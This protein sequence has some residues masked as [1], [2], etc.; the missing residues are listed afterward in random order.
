MT[1][2]RNRLLY[3]ISIVIVIILGLF[4]RKM[5]DKMPYFLKVYLGDFLWALMIFIVVAF[6]FNKMKTIKVVAIALIFCYVVEISQMYHANWID[7]IRSTTLGGLILGY[8]FSWNDL[9]A[10]A[11]G[12]AV[13]FVIDEFINKIT[14]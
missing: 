9:L 1:H 10:Y 12:V 14:K 8:T 11:V 7:N 2:R 4:L 3:G 5:V 6:I 13:G